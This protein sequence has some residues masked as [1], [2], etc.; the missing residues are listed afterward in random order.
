[1][2]NTLA[3]ATVT[4]TLR[5]TIHR[6]LPGSGVGGALVTTLRLDAPSGLP[7][8]GVNI[9]LYQVTPNLAWQN[10]DL[11]TRRADGSLLRRPQAALDL[12]YLLTFYGEDVTLDQ[13][14]LLG[15]TV[16]ELHAAPVLSRDVIRRVQAHVPS[17]NDSNLADQVD[18]VR[19]TPANLSL[20]DMNQL[21]MTF[22]N[23]DYIL[24]IAYVAG[25]VLI[26][27]DD[28]PP[29]TALPVLRR[30][31]L[32]VPSS[33]A[34]IDSVQPQPVDLS[35]SS[36]TAITL[37]G[38]NLDPSDAAAFATPGVTGLLYGTV[39]PGTKGDPAR[40]HPPGR[41]ARGRQLGAVDPVPHRAADALA[42][43]PR[44]RP[45][46]CSGLHHPARDRGHQAGLNV[47]SARGRCVALGRPQ[48]A[49]LVVAEPIALGRPRPAGLLAA[50]PGRD[51]AG[52]RPAGGAAH[53]RIRHRHLRCFRHP[54]R[55][56]PARV[57]RRPGRLDPGR[58]LPGAR[59]ASTARRAGWWSIPPGGTA[60]RPRASHE[61]DRDPGLAD[62]QPGRPRRGDWPGSRRS[63]AATP[64][65]SGG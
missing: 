16:L 42:A 33:L 11:P 49:G 63:C 45:D 14:R 55:L 54:G 62:A 28:E 22:P 47:R 57:R 3:I 1:M 37:I 5:Y 24:S 23:V 34:A 43:T 9:F 17:L 7:N 15:A 10:A 52:V 36:P 19:V 20:E 53:R 48:P 46:Q 27:T 31:V 2:S 51:P 25:A 58:R 6:A 50:R 4:E 29:G 38:S 41:P 40:R 30:R 60:A 59:S 8:P 64:T 26:E 32:A 35:S 44:D 61:R 13:Q 18:L 56:D 39:Q 21:W 12:H 65:A